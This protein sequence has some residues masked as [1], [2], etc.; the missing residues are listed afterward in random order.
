[1]SYDYAT[2]FFL[3]P[4]LYL[5]QSH[6]IK[7]AVK[8]LIKENNLPLWDGDWA[9]AKWPKTAE[10]YQAWAIATG[11]HIELTPGISFLQKQIN[12]L[13]FSADTTKLETGSPEKI[14]RSLYLES[15]HVAK[16]YV[17]GF[18]NLISEKSFYAWLNENFLRNPGSNQLANTQFI[19][20][21]EYD[22]GS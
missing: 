17:H 1:M 16:N 6:M 14:M 9:E 10:G 15:D 3:E 22:L 12:D 13:I 5:K 19:W 4:T 7:R 11:R 20:S 21:K 18:K 8:K 2:H